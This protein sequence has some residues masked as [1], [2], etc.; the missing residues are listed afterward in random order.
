MTPLTASGCEA[1]HFTSCGPGVVETGVG[2]WEGGFQSIGMICF[3][4]KRAYPSTSVVNP[5]KV[6]LMEEI[7]K[8]PPGMYKTCRK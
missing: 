6:L 2:G 3:G 8:Q 1:V 4:E 5:K 7:P